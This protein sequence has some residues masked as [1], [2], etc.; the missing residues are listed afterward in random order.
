[1]SYRFEGP[2]GARVL[3]GH[4]GTGSETRVHPSVRY[5]VD[6]SDVERDGPLAGGSPT[7][8]RVLTMVDALNASGT[9]VFVDPD[10]FDEAALVAA[11]ARV[12]RREPLWN[13]LWFDRDTRPASLPGLAVSVLRRPSSPS[14]TDD[15]EAQESLTAPPYRGTIRKR[16]EIRAA[17]D[18]RIGL[19]RG[20]EVSLPDDE[21]M[22][23][24]ASCEHLVVPGTDLRSPDPAESRG[25]VT[26][27]LMGERPGELR[28]PVRLPGGLSAEI[29][30]RAGGRSLRGTALSIPE[31]DAD[32]GMHPFGLHG[33]GSG[34]VTLAEGTTFAGGFRTADGRSVN[35]TAA[36]GGLV[37]APDDSG[38]SHLRP[39][40]RFTVDGAGAESTRLICGL[41]GFEFLD[42]GPEAAIE[43]VTGP[44][45]LTDGDDTGATS[46]ISAAGEPLGLLLPGEPEH[47][48]PGTGPWI[49]GR[50]A[51]TGRGSRPRGR[52]SRSCLSVAST[53]T[54][55]RQW[56]PRSRRSCPGDE[57]PS[58]SAP[59]APGPEPTNRRPTRWPPASSMVSPKEDSGS[60]SPTGPSSVSTWPV[61][62]IP[63]TPIARPRCWQSTSPPRRVCE[64][65]S[66][67]TTSS[68]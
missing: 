40:G 9:V 43:F 60:R 3:V 6:P 24:I 31:T 5:L 29:G 36:G 44:S 66:G 7:R 35:L 19:G 21:P 14:V 27:D 68:S 18:L 33:A 16:A 50:T 61:S 4:S 20:V 64:R 49:P 67:T 56:S 51:G 53:V 13:L 62:P 59:S 17:D 54:S 55:S 32:I 47:P 45:D 28:C 63:P 52:P 39:V 12:R 38:R 34:T 15:D 22:L 58:C 1:M 23:T 8:R 37:A 11:A 2:P 48:A 42:L 25:E 57:T 10:R 26:L 41:A 30:Y 46:W 65:R